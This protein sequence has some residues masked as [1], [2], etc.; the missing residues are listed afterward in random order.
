[1][2][3]RFVRARDFK[4]GFLGGGIRQNVLW[5][6]GESS[7]CCE[8]QQREEWDTHVDGIK[9]ILLCTTEIGDDLELGNYVQAQTVRM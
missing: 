9:R 8:G 4:G 2:D 7:R 5:R 6:G 3:S 1:L